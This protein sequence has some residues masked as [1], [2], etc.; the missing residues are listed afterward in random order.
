MK[1]M[2][3]ACAGKPLALRAMAIPEC[4]PE[5]VLIRVRACAVCRTDLHVCDGD[6]PDPKLPLIPGHEIVGEIVECGAMVAGV[7][8]GDCVEIGR[9]HV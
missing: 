1:A 5:Q 7:A 6:L 4:G 3:L 8:T 9:A 2:V